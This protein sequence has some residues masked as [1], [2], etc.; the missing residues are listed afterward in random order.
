MVTQSLCCVVLSADCCFSPVGDQ[1]RRA[2]FI[3]SKKILHTSVM[4]I[5]PKQRCSGKLMDSFRAQLKADDKD[6]LM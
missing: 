1:D 6:E 4:L 2:V 5:T 3:A